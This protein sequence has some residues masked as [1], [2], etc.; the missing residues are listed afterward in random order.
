[1]DMD[2]VTMDMDDPT[3]TSAVLTGA[4]SMVAMVSDDCK[5]SVSLPHLRAA[6]TL[7]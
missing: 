2:T 1:M 4:T 3:P 5:I 7:R 6:D